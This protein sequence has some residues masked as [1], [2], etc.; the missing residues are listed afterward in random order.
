MSAIAKWWSRL[1]AVLSAVVL[2][3]FVPVAAWAASG[4]GELA[5]EAARRRRGGFGFLGFFCCL[6]VVVV[7]VLLILRMT[8]SRRGP[9]R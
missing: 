1:T 7:I 6:I 5:V 4:P 8:R 3:V 9:R 2:A